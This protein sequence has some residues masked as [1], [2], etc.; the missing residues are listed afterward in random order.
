MYTFNSLS[1]IVLCCR[2]LYHITI[3]HKSACSVK[4]TADL[5]IYTHTL[6]LNRALQSTEKRIL[7]VKRK[8]GR[9][10]GA[11]K[12]SGSS[13]AKKPTTWLLRGRE[14]NFVSLANPMTQALAII[15]KELKNG[16]VKPQRLAAAASKQRKRDAFL[17]SQTKPSRW[18]MDNE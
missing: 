18:I 16:P 14:K 7:A 10:E 4:A 11:I 15:L 9:K 13:P 5:L 12:F 6:N 2:Q 17:P 1:L 3:F 8:K